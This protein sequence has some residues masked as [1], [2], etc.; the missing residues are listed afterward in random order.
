MWAR[1]RLKGPDPIKHVKDTG[2]KTPG[3]LFKVGT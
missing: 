1:R 2:A 3:E